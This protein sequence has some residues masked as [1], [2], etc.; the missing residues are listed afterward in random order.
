MALFGSKIN[1]LRERKADEEARVDFSE[2][3]F[4]LVF[5]FAITQISHYLL[6]HLSLDGLVNTVILLLAVWFAWVYTIWATNWFDPHRGPVRLLLFELMLAGLFLSTSLPEAFGE[7]AFVFAI[8]Y[9]VTQVGRSLFMIWATRHHDPANFR[10]FQR[11]GAWFAFSGIFWL[12]GS[13]MEELAWQRALWVAALA[14]EFV[15]PWFGYRVPGLGVSTTKDWQ[16]DGHHMAERSG[17][18]VIIALGESILIA[19]AT[20]TEM[21]WSAPVAVAFIAAFVISVAMWWI[22]FNIGAEHSRE[23]IAHSDDPG[24][25]ARIAYSYVHAL[26]VAGIIVVAVGVELMLAHPVGHH[27]GLPVILTLAGGACAYVIGNGLF[28]AL[29][30]GRWP[31]SHYVGIACLALVGFAARYFDP[32]ALGIAVSAVLVLVAAWEFLSLRSLR[33]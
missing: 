30:F 22:Y 13:A 28:K 26:I 20:F 32:L 2:L 23:R 21:A 18:F 3:F 10:S 1:Y 14:I 17:L 15:A 6:H 9:V 31:L 29:S 12:V 5:V 27:A 11:I 7:R 25:I 8:A 4:D 33:N 16:I 24:R 19:G